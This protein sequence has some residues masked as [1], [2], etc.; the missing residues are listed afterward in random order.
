MIDPPSHCALRT[1]P[2]D[3]WASWAGLWDT[4]LSSDWPCPAHGNLSAA[5]LYVFPWDQLLVTSQV[6]R[7]AS[8]QAAKG[9]EE[10]I[11][12]PPACPPARPLTPF[13]PANLRAEFSI[14]WVKGGREHLSLLHPLLSQIGTGFHRDGHAVPPGDGTEIWTLGRG[15]AGSPKEA[16]LPDHTHPEVGLGMSVQPPVTPRP[17]AGVGNRSIPADV[18]RDQERWLTSRSRPQSFVHSLCSTTVLSPF[19]SLFIWCSF[20][21]FN[22]HLWDAY[23]MTGTVPNTRDTAVSK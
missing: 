5:R 1:L 8:G 15:N 2:S 22:R 13:V 9:N 12:F 20:V 17:Q 3:D 16:S 6:L 23:L 18:V 11:L 19:A 14:P 7:E 21:S 10:C 4:G